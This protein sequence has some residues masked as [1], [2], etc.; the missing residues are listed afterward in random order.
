[1]VWSWSG[2]S[3]CLSW[4]ASR[5]RCGGAGRGVE[6]KLQPATHERV[7]EQSRKARGVSATRPPTFFAN[8]KNART[9]E[10]EPGGAVNVV[11][12]SQRIQGDRG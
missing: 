5:V 11:Q 6:H 4:T 3:G 2:L 10:M 12:P 9:D 7:D 1:V 8:N